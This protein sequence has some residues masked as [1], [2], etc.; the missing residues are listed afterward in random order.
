MNARQKTRLA[1]YGAMALLLLSAGMTL[2]GY[3]KLMLF[4]TYGSG[5]VLYVAYL[6]LKSRKD[7]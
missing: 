2:A 5:A 4:A 3:P 1:G 6:T 7:R